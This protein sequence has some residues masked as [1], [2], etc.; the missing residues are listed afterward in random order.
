MS[1]ELE[2][3]QNG[4]D[5][6]SN[7]AILNPLHAVT[8]GKEIPQ[9]EVE[10]EHTLQETVTAQLCNPADAFLQ[11]SAGNKKFGSAPFWKVRH[12]IKDH[13]D[14]NDDDDGKSKEQCIPIHCLL[15]F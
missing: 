11:N 10:D 13:Q 2:L 1:H 7:H 14:D 9:Q 8:S 5:L 12:S 6:F 15:H 3:L 4:K